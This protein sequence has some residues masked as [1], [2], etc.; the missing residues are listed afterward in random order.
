MLRVLW[1]QIYDQ[2]QTRCC[3]T[4]RSVVTI[5]R[6]DYTGVNRWN[7]LHTCTGSTASLQSRQTGW[8]VSKCFLEFIQDGATYK[9]P[10]F[11]RQLIIS[12]SRVSSN[13]YCCILLNFI[14]SY[15]DWLQ[16]L[17]NKRWILCN[18]PINGGVL[19]K[20][21]KIKV[22]RICQVSVSQFSLLH[23][24]WPN[25]LGVWLILGFPLME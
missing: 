18:L 21:N 23:Y 7:S 16:L 13:D 19:S 5:D 6:T 15:F 25:S 11:R 8:S 4:N 14:F 24:S 20:R 2:L 22:V 17:K 3:Q 9:F 12:Q 1:L 10:M